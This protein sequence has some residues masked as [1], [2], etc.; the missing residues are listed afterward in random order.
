MFRR[1]KKQE[2]TDEKNSNKKTFLG[3]KIKHWMI[4]Y[5]TLVQ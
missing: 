5:L 2:L 3:E 4:N 1:K